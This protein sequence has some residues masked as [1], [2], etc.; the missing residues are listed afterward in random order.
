MHN[1]WNSQLMQW[2]KIV[3][4]EFW[5][6]PYISGEMLIITLCIEE[7]HLFISFFIRGNASFH[8]IFINGRLKSPVHNVSKSW[9]LYQILCKLMVH[10]STSPF[11]S[12]APA[13]LLK[14]S[15]NLNLSIILVNIYHIHEYKSWV[16]MFENIY[17]YI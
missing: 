17:M 5:N 3:D 4:R 8:F 16:I 1:K 7:M 15:K 2:K 10:C 11:Y 14:P 12:F 9:F 13:Q 6:D